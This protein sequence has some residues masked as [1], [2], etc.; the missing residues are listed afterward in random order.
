M[1]LEKISIILMNYNLDESKSSIIWMNNSVYGKAMENISKRL[2]I[3]IISDVE[4]Y[5]KLISKPN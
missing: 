2:D 4:K 1:I 5:E 3:K